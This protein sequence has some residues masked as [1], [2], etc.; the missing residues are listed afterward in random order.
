M[1]VND[2][3]RWNINEALPQNL[4]VAIEENHENFTRITSLEV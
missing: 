1:F 2:E 4:P 3:L